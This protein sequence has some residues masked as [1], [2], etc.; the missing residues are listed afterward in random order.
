MVKGSP[1][2]DNLK[3]WL[4]FLNSC[5]W[6]SGLHEFAKCIFFGSDL[7]C[8]AHTSIL[9]DYSWEQSNPNFAYSFCLANSLRTNSNKLES[10]VAV[11]VKRLWFYTNIHISKIFFQGKYLSSLVLSEW[12]QG[13]KKGFSAFR[14]ETL[15]ST[16]LANPH[17]VISPALNRF[18]FCSSC[19][20]CCCDFVWSLIGILLCFF[21]S[22]C[23]ES[24]CPNVSFS[25]K[26]PTVVYLKPNFLCWQPQSCHKLSFCKSQQCYSLTVYKTA[27]TLHLYLNLNMYLYVHQ[28]L[29]WQSSF[30]TSVCSILQLISVSV[31]S[32]YTVESIWRKRRIC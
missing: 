26:K 11:S 9:I 7:T 14:V 15:L 3:I 21:I 32:D 12:K 27:I 20:F 22:F 30:H 6:L 17:A 10:Y 23:L 8:L 28:Y 19:H 16:G 4:W 2:Q 13:K 25:V 18:C 31:I 1:Q 29:Y 5:Y 24:F